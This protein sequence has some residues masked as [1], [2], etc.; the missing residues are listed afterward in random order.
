MFL[1]DGLFKTLK[2]KILDP[3]QPLV[4]PNHE[5]KKYTS[6]N[7]ACY[8]YFVI[9]IKNHNFE[10]IMTTNMTAFNHDYKIIFFILY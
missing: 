8:I 3:P 7:L 2:L 1:L 9:Q 6:E 10:N 5:A 4:V